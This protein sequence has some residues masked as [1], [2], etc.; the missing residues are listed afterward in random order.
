MQPWLYQE[1]DSTVVGLV[2]GRNSIDK[3]VGHFPRF[4]VEI[5]WT[6]ALILVPHSIGYFPGLQ[7]RFGFNGSEIFP[8]FSMEIDGTV[9]YWS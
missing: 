4:H 3:S 1:L 9:T 2:L 6:F 8:G 5:D 7:H